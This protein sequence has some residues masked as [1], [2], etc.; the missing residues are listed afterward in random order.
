MCRKKL[1]KYFT[2]RRWKKFARH[3]SKSNVVIHKPFKFSCFLNRK[4]PQNLF[5]SFFSSQN[6]KFD[7]NYINPSEHFPPNVKHFH[8]KEN[9]DFPNRFKQENHI[10][11]VD[12]R[13]FLA[14]CNSGEMK[15]AAAFLATWHFCHFSCKSFEMWKVLQSCSNR[16][17]SKNEKKKDFQ[18]FFSLLKTLGFISSSW[19]FHRQCCAIHKKQQQKKR[20]NC[21]FMEASSDNAKLY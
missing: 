7:N 5:K 15:I 2:R 21:L 10:V 18:G 12:L 13:I 17:L 14:S 20:N 16:I 8:T 11:W 4:K 19:R 3:W 6:E 1:K 9:I